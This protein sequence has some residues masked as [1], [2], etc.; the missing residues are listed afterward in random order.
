MPVV[1]I[2]CRP[3]TPQQRSA[4]SAAVIAAVVDAFDVTPDLVQVFIDEYDD[5]CWSRGTPSA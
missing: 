4:V 2:R 3:K 5:T 1:T